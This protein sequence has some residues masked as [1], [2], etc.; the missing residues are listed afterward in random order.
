VSPRI[1][2]IIPVLNEAAYVGRLLAS[3]DNEQDIE[4]IVVDGGSTDDT[5][6]ELKRFPLLK[7]VNSSLGRGIQMN[8]PAPRGEVSE[9]CEL[10]I[11][12]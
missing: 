4:I 12:M 8:N 2:I 5:L 3:L 9:E 7:I 10:S 1:S 11:I 6:T